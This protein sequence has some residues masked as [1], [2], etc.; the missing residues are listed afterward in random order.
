MGTGKLSKIFSKA[1]TKPKLL[2]RNIEE[3]LCREVKKLG[4]HAYKFNSRGRMSVPDRLCIFPGGLDYFVECKRPGE[5]ARPLQLDEHKKLKDL[6]KIV[7]VI[8][9]YEHVDNF[10]A[11]ITA[12]IEQRSYE[13]VGRCSR[14]KREK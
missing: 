1:A 13:A 4:G 2:E 11:A 7:L 14:Y 12:A 5:K 9:T 8:S 3:R 10:I 6:G